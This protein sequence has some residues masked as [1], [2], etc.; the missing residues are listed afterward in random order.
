MGYLDDVTLGGSVDSVSCDV[1]EIRRV[2]SKMGL[3]L[4]PSKCELIAPKETTVTDPFLQ[5]FITTEIDNACLIGAPLFPGPALE[6]TWSDRCDDLSKA[7]DRLAKFG[8]QDALI[9][10]RLSFS[11]QK[12]LHLLRCS[13][14]VSHPLLDQF[15]SLLRSAVQRIT[16]TDLS[17][18]QWMQASLPVKDGGLGVRRVSSLSL[19]A[20]LASAASS[21]SLQDAILSNSVSSASTICTNYQGWKNH[22][23]KKKLKNQIFLFKS[24]FF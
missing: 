10:L 14:S 16:N 12:V 13:P 1:A 9:Q 3:V 19:P 22:D 11:A 18:S 15:D 8:S 5:S 2:G 21:L 6:K 23:F 4:N 17:D 20:Y 24:D 7:V